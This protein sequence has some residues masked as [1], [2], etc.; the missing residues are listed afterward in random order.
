MIYEWIDIK[1][2]QQANSLIARLDE[3]QKELL[4]KA[5]E[6]AK[7]NEVNEYKPTDKDHGQSFTQDLLKPEFVKEMIDFFSKHQP[8]TPIKDSDA[9]FWCPH[10]TVYSDRKKNNYC[11]PIEKYDENG[12][13]E[14]IGWGH[15]SCITGEYWEE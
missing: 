10:I 15:V 6:K 9:W 12:I 5:L 3:N 7:E 13:V 2:Y 14:N 1:D 4:F 11:A 8:K